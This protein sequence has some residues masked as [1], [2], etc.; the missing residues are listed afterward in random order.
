MLGVAASAG[1][2]D[3]MRSG[4]GVRL[5]IWTGATGFHSGLAPKRSQAALKSMPSISWTKPY[6]V[7]VLIAHEAMAKLLG[8]RDVERWVVVRM[9]WAQAD[10][11]RAAL[12]ELDERRND[13]NNVVVA[14]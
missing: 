5:A 3:V 7:V 1:G 10:V 6:Y 4:S 12:L 14:L 9:E 11:L 8:G 2:F 13:R